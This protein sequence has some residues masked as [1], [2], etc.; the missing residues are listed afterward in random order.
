M[1]P[2]LVPHAPGKE[3]GAFLTASSSWLYPAEPEAKTLDEPLLQQSRN[4]PRCAADYQRVSIDF[5]GI[6]KENTFCPALVRVGR[7]E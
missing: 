6:S 1:L 7:E 4:N 2:P 3:R 5:N